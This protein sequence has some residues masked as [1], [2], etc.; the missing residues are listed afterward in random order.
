MVSNVDKL[1]SV[2]QVASLLGISDKTVYRMCHE[3]V[4]PHAYVGVK[5]AIRIPEGAV[6]RYVADQLT[7]TQRIVVVDQPPAEL[8]TT[9]GSAVTNSE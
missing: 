2:G 6:E 8:E 7:A 5:A 3:K 1:L 9:L 4:L